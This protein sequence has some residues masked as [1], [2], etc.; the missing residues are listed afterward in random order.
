MIDPTN[1]PLSKDGVIAVSWAPLRQGLLTRKG[2]LRGDRRSIAL[3]SPYPTHA[4]FALVQQSM[5]WRKAA[6]WLS[7]TNL[8]LSSLVITE[9]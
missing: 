9:F 1:N 8:G 4:E 2:V 3:T 5:A 6:G 7:E